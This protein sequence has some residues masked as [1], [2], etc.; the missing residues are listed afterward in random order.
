MAPVLASNICCQYRFFQHL[1]QGRLIDI[2]SSFF[3]SISNQKFSKLEASANKSTKTKT[4]HGLLVEARWMKADNGT[5]QTTKTVPTK[6]LMKG[7]NGA[8]HQKP[9]LVNGKKTVVNGANL[10][11]R[12]STSRPVKSQK[13]TSTEE[14]PFTDELEVLDSGAEGFSWAMDNYSAWQRTTDVWTF[15]LSLRLRVLFDDAK[16]TYLNGFTEEEHVYT[17]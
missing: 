7:S 9:E 10:D 4:L 12:V 16:W 3:G 8:S 6:D 11:E 15:V 5:E 17:L 14:S 13:R 2:D 1:D